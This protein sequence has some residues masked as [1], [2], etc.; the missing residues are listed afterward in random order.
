MVANRK[1][2][3]VI[4]RPVTET[5]L[6]FDREDLFTLIADALPQAQVILLHG[7]RRIGKSSV[8]AQIPL[9]LCNE[10]YTFV[11]L[12]LEGKSQKSLSQ[13]LSELAQEVV[14]YL[15][16]GI[17]VPSEEDFRQQPQQFADRVLAQAYAQMDRS[18]LV[19]LFD[20][21]DTLGNYHPDAAATHLFP[22][23]SEVLQ[24]H[25]WLH[26]I[27]VVG[28]RLQ[29]LPTLLGLFRNAPNYEIDLLDPESTRQ[30]ITTPAQ[31]LLQYD[32]T[33]IQAILE[34]AAG[35]PYFTQV[36]CFTL[37][38]Q[39]REQDC[40]QVSREQVYQAIDRAIEFGE[41]GL[42]W[43][44]DGLPIPERV[45][46]AAAATV[47]ELKWEEGYSLEIKE[48]EPL[49]FLEDS[50]VMLTECLHRAQQN[51]LDWHYLWPLKQVYTP[52]TVERS[53]YKVTIELVRRWLL[54]RHRVTQEIWQLQDLEPDVRPTYEAARDWRHRGQLYQAIRGYEQVLSLNPNHLSALFELADC[55]GAT[56]AYSRAIECYERAYHID[57]VRAR[58]GLLRARIGYAR[59][60]WDRG[61]ELEAERSLQRVLDLEPDHEDAQALLQ[62]IQERQNAPFKKEKSWGRFIPEWRW[63]LF[64][65]D[66]PQGSE[67]WRDPSDSN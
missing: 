34:L 59:T 49:S 19:L 41:G 35:H 11:L 26:I 50:G 2:P 31:G 62:L 42:A 63:N 23:L 67:G 16:L 61:Q 3:Y 15:N 48:G 51:L 55:L 12:S 38:T 4:G 52:E 66:Q 44:W 30:L 53:T 17:A 27:P 1:N 22:F 64:G 56:Q 6:F 8:L 36:L 21:F 58:D 24:D 7:Q 25:P 10:G 29:D 40:W 47:A 32:E 43:F 20:E 13:V 57:P 65:R 60:L 39:A 45:C 37:F 33:A 18:E 46:F 5:A 28:R 14:D 9:Q 54:R